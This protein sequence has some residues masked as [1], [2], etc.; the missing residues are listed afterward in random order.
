MSESLPR[1]TRAVG[2][3]RRSD[4]PPGDQGSGP[5]RAV[6]TGTHRKPCVLLVEDH[7][8]T[9]ELY[10]WIMRAAGWQVETATNGLEALVKASVTQPD[11]IVMDVNLPVLDGIAATR[12]L[13]AD[14]RTAHIPVVACSALDLTHSDEVVSAGFDELVAK[15]CTPEGLRDIVEKLV[16]RR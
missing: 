1:S 5:K 12:R 2:A 9:R 7:E 8:D 14:E 16:G 15:P 3:A 4:R 6:E 11:V 13:K 10:A